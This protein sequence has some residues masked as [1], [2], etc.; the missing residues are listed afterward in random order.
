MEKIKPIRRHGCSMSV[1]VRDALD[2]LGWSTPSK[3]IQERIGVCKLWVGDTGQIIS[4]QYIQV[5][6]R[7]GMKRGL[8]LRSKSIPDDALDWI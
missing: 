5:V 4:T 1:V 6:R 8:H 7:N 3:V 2:E